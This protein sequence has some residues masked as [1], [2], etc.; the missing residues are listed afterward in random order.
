MVTILQTV[1]SVTESQN[2]IS[3]LV[4]LSI[5]LTVQNSVE[6]TPIPLAKFCAK[7]V[8][9][10]YSSSLRKDFQDSVNVLIISTPSVKELLG[11]CKKSD[12]DL[13]SQSISL[14]KTSISLY[15]ILH[16]SFFLHVLHYMPVPRFCH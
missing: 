12:T 1:V 5:A 10:L 11:F 3:K 2:L 4:S 8:N 6:L 7:P 16:R 15:K 14:I 9:L 13:H